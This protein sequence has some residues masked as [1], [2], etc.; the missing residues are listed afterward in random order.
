MRRDV[1]AGDHYG[2]TLC[3]MRRILY[4]LW[5]QKQNQFVSDCISQRGKYV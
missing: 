1:T 3:I 4:S 5:A 2:I